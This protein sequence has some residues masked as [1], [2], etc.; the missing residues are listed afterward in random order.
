MSATGDLVVTLIE[1]IDK[2]RSTVRTHL[3]SIDGIHAARADDDFRC[4]VC[5]GDTDWPCATSVAIQALREALD[6]DGLTPTIRLES[7]GG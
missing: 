6:A 3:D 1:T 5:V 7:T 2:T 4:S